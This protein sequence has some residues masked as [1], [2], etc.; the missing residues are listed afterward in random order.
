MWAAGP[1][2]AIDAIAAGHY[3]AES[4]HR[5]V[6]GGHMTI[7]RNKWEFNE[8]DKDNIRVESYDNSS[9]QIEGL[10]ASV[11]EKSFRDAHLTLT[12]EQ[13]KKETARCLG[14]GATIVDENKCIGCGVCTTKC[15]FDAITLHRDRP[16]CTTM[17]TAEDKF[18]AIIPY[19]LKRAVKIMTH[20]KS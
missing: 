18:K 13:V 12:E 2:F 6:Q 7:G 5:Y 20:K 19:Q 3:A 11:P 9:R 15:E 8:L 14:C 16:E 1:K 10:D 4:L 17:V